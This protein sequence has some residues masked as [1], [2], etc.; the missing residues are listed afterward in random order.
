MNTV[1]T[2]PAIADQTAPASNPGWTV[3]PG[4]RQEGAG[5]DVDDAM[6]VVQRQDQQDVIG[7]LPRQASTRVVTW[8]WMFPWVITTPL[9][10]LVVP[11]V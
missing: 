1:S 3:T 10:R 2:P 7:R 11:L 8:A 5:E 4:A 9:G 6:D